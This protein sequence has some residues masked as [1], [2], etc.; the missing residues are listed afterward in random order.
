MTEGMW[1]VYNRFSVSSFDHV[2]NLEPLD[3]CVSKSDRLYGVNNIR[4]E[5]S[6][7]KSFF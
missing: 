2:D 3:I 1:I 4:M 6:T 7:Y 5:Y